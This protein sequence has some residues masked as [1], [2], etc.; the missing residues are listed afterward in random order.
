MADNSNTAQVQTQK[1]LSYALRM[2][3]AHLLELHVLQVADFAPSDEMSEGLLTELTGFLRK[4]GMYPLAMI[5]TNESEDWF[6]YMRGKYLLIG[7]DKNGRVHCSVAR[8]RHQVVFDPED[9]CNP[10]LAPKNGA[11]T[12]ILFVKLYE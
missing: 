4:E 5:L 12:A 6:D 8:G 3:V 2:C 1:T 10:P 9:L 11:L 7:L